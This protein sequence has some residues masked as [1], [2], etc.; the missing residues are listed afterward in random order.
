MV[1][2]AILRLR[3]NGDLARCQAIESSGYLDVMS[4]YCPT[5]S[6]MFLEILVELVG[7]FCGNRTS[8]TLSEIGSAANVSDVLKQYISTAVQQYSSI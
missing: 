4:R 5:L 3:T 2:E 7:D 1:L 8:S 6:D